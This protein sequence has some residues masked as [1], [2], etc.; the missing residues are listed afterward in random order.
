VKAVRDANREYRAHRRVRL[1]YVHL[2]GDIDKFTRRLDRLDGAIERAE[3]AGADVSAA[4]AE[5]R[6]GWKALLEVLPP[7]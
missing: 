6:A 2:Q 1:L 5:F 7:G 3:E 4:A